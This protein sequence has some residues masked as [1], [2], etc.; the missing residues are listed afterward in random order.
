MEPVTANDIEHIGDAMSNFDHIIDRDVEEKLKQGNCIADYPAWNFH[1]TL[2]F[3]GENFQCQIK[4]YQVHVDT[5]E[6]PT[7][8]E[9]MEKASDRWGHD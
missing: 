9:I 8:E 5:I 7:L 4:R 1:G 2:W 3:N 6:A